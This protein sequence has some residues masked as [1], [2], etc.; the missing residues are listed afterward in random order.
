MTRSSNSFKILDSHNMIFSVLN[1]IHKMFYHCQSWSQLMLYFI[2]NAR[3]IKMS[4]ISKDVVCMKTMGLSKCSK[5]KS[6]LKGLI[7]ETR[8]QHKRNINKSFNSHAHKCDAM[9]I[10]MVT[11]QCLNKKLV[12]VRDQ[13]NISVDGTQRLYPKNVSKINSSK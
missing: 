12:I 7:V 8:K 9:L 10:D 5:M 13:P 4:Q 6:Q 3:C 1:G 11:S 2:V